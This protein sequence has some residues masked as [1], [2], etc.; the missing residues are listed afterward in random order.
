MTQASSDHAAPASSGESS[1]MVVLDVLRGVAVLGI[2]LMNIQSFGRISSEYINPKALGDPPALDWVV[3]II[4]HIVADEKFI[5]MLTVLFGAGIVIMANASRESAREFEQR[6]RRRMFWLFLFGLAHGLLLWPGDILAA[7]AICGAIALQLRNREPAELLWYA[8]LLFA[9]ATILWMIFSAGL[10]FVLPIEWVNQLATA[11]WMPTASMVH[12]EVERLTFN[13][14]GSIGERAMD[15]LASQAW[16][17]V[18][19]RVWRMLAMMLLGMA[20]MKVGFLSGQWTLRSYQRVAVGGLVIGVPVILAGLLFNE[21]VN[22]DFRYSMFLG[23]IANHWASVAVALAWI[24]IV[25]LLVH[26]GVFRHALTCL[27]AVG[28]LAMTNYLAQSF[29]CVP[30]FY[31][32]GFGLYSQLGHLQLLGVVMSVWAIQIAFSLLWRQFFRMGPFEFV[33]RRLARG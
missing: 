30:I 4:N 32:V 31:G 1:R 33:W 2:L 7:Y 26:G 18:S 11:Y 27:E 28:R 24:S 22:W 6:Y 23:R 20:L 5:T 21:A 10:V 17:L 8:L 12:E 3:W 13:W 29:I 25:I 15:A 16:M 9:S 14:S 19:D